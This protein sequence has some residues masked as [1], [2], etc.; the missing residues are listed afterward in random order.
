MTY[1]C[2]ACGVGLEINIIS[3]PGEEDKFDEGDSFQICPN[4]GSDD[5]HL[6]EE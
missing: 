4:C 2:D 6:T 3:V 5:L 1:E